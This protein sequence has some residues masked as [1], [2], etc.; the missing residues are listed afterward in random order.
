MKTIGMLGGMTWASSA[1]YYDLLNRAVQKRLG[2]VHSAKTL[3]YSF[4]FGEIAALQDAGR[5]DDASR[6]LEDAGRALKSGNADFLIICCNTMH[7]MSDA[8]ER[9]AGV[10]LLHI[11]DPLADEIKRRDIARVGL[12]GSRHTMTDDA[13]I[14]GRL[15]QR[16][17]EVLVP[18]GDDFAR[19][20]RIVY[21][22]MASGQFLDQ[23]R[24]EARAIIAKM[25]AKGAQGVVLG[26]TEFPILLKADDASVPLFDTTTLHAMAAVERALA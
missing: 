4:D 5:W 10:P 16:G 20:D 21:A 24:R 2:G 17:I 25:A 22:E 8:V 11:A 7:R 13:I 3:M 18:E 23:S 15:K 6:M 19:I 26:C 9:A 12:I 14:A 1:V